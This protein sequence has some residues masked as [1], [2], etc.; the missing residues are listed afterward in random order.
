M[1]T[2]IINNISTI[3][4]VLFLSVVVTKILIY[5]IKMKKDKKSNCLNCS[6]NCCVNC[7]LNTH[8]K[9]KKHR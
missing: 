4:V 2:F 8:N 5:L 1:I 9:M 3:I 7:S 6:N